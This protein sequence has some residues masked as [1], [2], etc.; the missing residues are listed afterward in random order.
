MEIMPM[1]DMARTTE[2]KLKASFPTVLDQPNY[3]YGL[4]IS[5]CDSE[6]EKLEIDYD[7]VNV[8]DIIHMHCF[9]VVT[10]KSSNVVQGTEPT[11]RIELQITHISA[12]DEA[13]EDQE[14]EDKEVLPKSTKRMSKLYSK[15]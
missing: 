13:E 7:D 14:D 8:D 9:A 12:E 3:P 1:V 4:S 5:L 10:S 15:K 6:L 2:E 11:C